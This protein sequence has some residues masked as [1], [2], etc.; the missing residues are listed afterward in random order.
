MTAPEPLV[1]AEVDLRDFG[2][3]PLDVRTLLTS[4]L[5]IKAKKDPRVAHA[6]V[7]LWCECWHQVP[8]ASLPDDDEVLADLARCDPKEWARIRERALLHFVK[9]SDG[10]LYHRHVAAKAV[11]AWASKQAQRARTKAATEAREARRREQQAARH[12]QRNVERDDVRNVER[13]VERHE[14][15]DDLRDE[16]RDVHQGTGTGTVKGQG[17]QKIKSESSARARPPIDPFAESPPATPSP[18]GEACRRM[19]DA[20]VQR[21]NPGDPRLLALLEQGVTP[22]QLGETAAE[23]V[24]GRGA[25]VSMALVVGTVAGRMRDAAAIAALPPG[26]ARKVG[27]G[28]PEFVNEIDRIAASIHGG[29]KPAD[30]GVI[31]VE[32]RDVGE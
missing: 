10:R 8:A 21:V 29:R 2:F 7:S 28:Q 19:R 27:R 15:R 6:A 17:Q 30:P 23:L 26:T 4:S 12:E 1:P 24:A 9:C 32:A 20:G 14:Q 31:D 25:D 16:S 3:M 18:A 5:W 22:L 13:N 11:E